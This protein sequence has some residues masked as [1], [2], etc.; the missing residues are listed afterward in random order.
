M[1]IKKPANHAAAG[2]TFI[3]REG[4]DGATLLGWP[5]SLCNNYNCLPRTHYDTFGYLLTDARMLA[6]HIKCDR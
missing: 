5:S 3:S 2:K 4:T 1:D 6:G